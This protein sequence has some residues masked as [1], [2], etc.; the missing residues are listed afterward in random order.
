MNVLIL[1]SLCVL[2]LYYITSRRSK[3]PPG[4]PTFKG[5]IKGEKMNNWAFDTSKAIDWFNAV[6]P[7][8]KWG[9]AVA[10]DAREML[11]EHGEALNGLGHAS[12]ESVLL[13]GASDWEQFSYGGCALCYDEE[14]AERYCTPSE[15]ERTRYGARRPN[16]RETWLDVQAR[17]LR[18][19]AVLLWR[20]GV[21]H[22]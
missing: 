10:A 1:Y 14:I 5:R 3:E 17:A 8:S 19:A 6:K 4:R 2:R 16:S 18:Q 11:M 15:L 21:R 22:V 9:R 12:F 20:R 7:R 13:N